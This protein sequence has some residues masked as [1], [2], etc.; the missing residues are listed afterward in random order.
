MIK[1]E[2]LDIIYLSTREPSDSVLQAGLIPRNPARPEMVDA[3]GSK[4]QPGHRAEP[5]C[6]QQEF[7]ASPRSSA[8][9]WSGIVP[10]IIFNCNQGT[11]NSCTSAFNTLQEWKMTHKALT[12]GGASLTTAQPL[13]NVPRQAGTAAW[14]SGGGVGIHIVGFF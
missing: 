13:M 11:K 10:S 12:S 2:L 14:N 5:W 1:R 3:P 9:V 4:A 6:H 7:P 8:K